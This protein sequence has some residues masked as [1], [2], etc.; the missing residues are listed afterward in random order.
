M[1]YCLSL[2][3]SGFRLP[4]ILSFLY[5]SLFTTDLHRKFGS[6]VHAVAQASKY[7]SV[8]FFVELFITSNDFLPYNPV[9]VIKTIIVSK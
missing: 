6:D 5:L 1:N 7:S 9:K 2:N 3:F 8:N 4:R